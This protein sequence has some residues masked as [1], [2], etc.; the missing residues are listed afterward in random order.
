MAW[1]ILTSCLYME[2]LR[3]EL[4]RPRS[5][6]E[7]TTVFSL[8]DGDAKVQVVQLANYGNC[9]RRLSIFW[10]TVWDWIWL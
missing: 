2:E 8:L 6:S 10:S 1:S 4:L 3:E 9:A 5:D 7:G